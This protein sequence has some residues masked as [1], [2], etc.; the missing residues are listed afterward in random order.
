[1]DSSSCFISL[2]V[3]TTSVKVALFD[4]FGT[5]LGTALEEYKLDTPAEDI[6]ELDPEKYWQCCRR[7]IRRV[8]EQSRVEPGTIRSIAACTQG[9]TLIV[10]DREGNPLRR[11]IVWMDNRSKQEA[12]EIKAHLGHNRNTGQVDIFPTW[13]ITKILWLKKNEPAVYREVDKYLLVEDYILFRLSGQVRGEYSLYTSSYMLDIVRKDWWQEILDFVGVNREQ[14][15]ELCEPG[16]IIGTV[17]PAVGQDL[18]LNPETLV[19]TGTMDQTAAMIGAGNITDGVVTETTGA[20]LVMCETIDA[21]PTV[22]SSNLAVQYH[23]IPGKFFLI[24]WCPAGGMTLKW[25]RDNFYDGEGADY[26]SM[27]AAAANVPPGSQGLF[28]FP[29][30][31]GPGTLNIDPNLRGV[32]YGLELHHT[33][34]HFVRA[35][36]EGIGFSLRENL[37]NIEEMGTSAKEILSLGGGARSALWNQ[38][39]ADITGKRITTM[40]CSETAALGVAVLQACA[41]ATYPDVETAVEQMVRPA[42]VVDPIPENVA[43]YEKAYQKYIQIERE[44]LGKR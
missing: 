11:A 27:T 28:F 32:F 38:I 44:Q 40:K 29:Y 6:V 22:P 8:V 15:P 31:A 24:G 37:Q 43:L 21:Y 25:F 13:P 12:D 26:N 5:M 18:G 23:A 9:E 33:R 17:D 7:G 36:L 19:V 14:L 3:G 35:I 41:T 42:Q 30:M 16:E 20:A 4:R 2:D 39:K 34:T 10:L 1:M